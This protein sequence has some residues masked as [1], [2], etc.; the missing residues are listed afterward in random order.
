MNVHVGVAAFVAAAE[1]KEE[2]EP[3]NGKKKREE[4][5]RGG[6]KKRTQKF[7]KLKA[8]KVCSTKSRPED[9]PGSPGFR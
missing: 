7:K 3:T 8:K 2:E 5:R 9:P 1:K 6:K 4:K